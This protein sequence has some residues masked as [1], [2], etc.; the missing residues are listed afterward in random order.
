VKTQTMMMKKQTLN[1]KN[2][3]LLSTFVLSQLHTIFRGSKY[4]V[5]WYLLIDYTRRIDYAVMYTTTA[6]NFLILAYCLHFPKGVKKEVSQFILIVT[7]LDMLHLILLS[8]LRFG[9]V[10]IF[11]AIIIYYVIRFFKKYV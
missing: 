3:F 8:R 6:I 2:Y 1:I 9:I 4:R 7:S 10:K 5:D 11:L